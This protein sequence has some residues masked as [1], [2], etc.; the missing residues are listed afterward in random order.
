[1][2]HPVWW[3][4]ACI[5]ILVLG[6]GYLLVSG[7][8]VASYRAIGAPTSAGNDAEFFHHFITNVLYIAFL[9]PFMITLFWLVRR[10][11]VA[12][13]FPA[14]WNA[15]KTMFVIAWRGHPHP[16]DLAPDD[17][18]TIDEDPMR[19]FLRGL[20]VAV[21]LPAF[22]WFA[23]VPFPHSPATAVWL[24]CVGCSAGGA[25]YCVER[26]RPFLK[27]GWLER[28]QGRWFRRWWS[29]SPSDYDPPGNRWLWAHWIFVV[30]AGALWLV[31]AAKMFGPPSL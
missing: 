30:L 15:A 24:L 4:R 11:R 18:L 31:G 2:K 16:D 27:K 8:L 3:Y 13:P 22:F 14:Y 7:R 25:V 19:A 9:A 12:E 23:P 1:M 17:D 10:Q 6:E 21:T 29:Q 28:Q 5:A 20:M 26:A